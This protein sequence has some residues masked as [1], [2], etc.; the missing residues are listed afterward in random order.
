MALIVPG[1]PVFAHWSDNFTAST[2][3]VAPGTAV[4]AGSTTAYVANEDGDPV[5]L[6]GALAHDCE[7]LVIAAHNGNVNGGNTSTL[8]DILVDPAGGTSWSEFI[9]DLLIG[10][11]IA[12]ASSAGV[13]RMYHFPVWLPAGTAI[14]ARARGAHSALVTPS[15]VAYAAG[16]NKNPA[17]WWCGQ[18]V[19]TVGTFD[20]ANSRGQAHTPGNTGT[21]SSWTSLGSPVAARGGAVQYAVQA[22][23]DNSL[24][25]RTYHFQFGAGSSPIGPTINSMTGTSEQAMQFFPGPIFCDIAAGTQ[26]QVRATCNST[27]VAQDCAAYLIQ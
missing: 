12:I 16:G 10:Y 19:E 21:Y 14:G 22:E 26:M 1:G 24:A 8:L 27:A 15:I 3:A 9:A 25:Q 4:P 6:I 18:K 2:P 5:G 7:Y 20:A 17:S 13:S 23:G 11:S